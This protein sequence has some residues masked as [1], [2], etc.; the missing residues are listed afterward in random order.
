MV[1]RIAQ[2]VPLHIPVPPPKYGG[3]ER[4][5]YNLVEGLVRAGH[6]V[7]LFASG[8]SHTSA[9]LV[10]YIDK[11]IFFNPEV[12][13]HA[14]HVAM[15][16]DIYRQAHKFDVIH[17]HLDYLTLPFVD[18]TDVP[19][20][21]TLHGRLDAPYAKV[22]LRRYSDASYVSISDSQRRDVPHLNWVA[23]V[24]HGVEVASFEFHPEPG[25]YLTF[26]GRMS[27]EKRP[28]VAIAVAKRTGIPLK[29]AAK[30]DH[31]ERKYFEHE[32]RPLM[33]DPLIEWLG[34][35][36]EAEKRDLMANALALLL[37]IDWPEPFGMV[38]IEALASGTPVVTCPRGSVPELLKDGVTGFSGCTVDELADA[39]ARIDTISRLACRR[40]AEERFDTAR[41]AADYVRVYERLQPAARTTRPSRQTR[42]GYPIPGPLLVPRPSGTPKVAKPPAALSAAAADH[43][44]SVPLP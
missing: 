31:K 21:I 33:D 25:R 15:L 42:P 8:D 34:E 35:V 16:T 3:T 20:I 9:R 43:V 38:F 1:M 12:D 17:S 13:A 19:T 27:P 7:T 23:T 29:I 37:P 44:E 4:V 39:V 32:I 2:I 41:M 30:V 18:S 28:D 14:F 5:V 6:D 22:A 26:V 36:E 11:H 24:H 10:P 40:Y